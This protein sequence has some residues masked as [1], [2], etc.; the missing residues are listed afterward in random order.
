MLFASADGVSVAARRAMK[1]HET[2][3]FPVSTGAG[4]RIL[5]STEPQLA[6]TVR[7]GKVRPEPPIFA[8]RRQWSPGHLLQAAGAMGIEL[9]QELRAE[10]EQEV[11]DAP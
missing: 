4:A 10:L 3:K 5:G 7:R 8:G 6:E 11:R 1:S 2:T 9:S